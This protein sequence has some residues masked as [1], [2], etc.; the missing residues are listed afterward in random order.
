MEEKCCKKCNS[1]CGLIGRKK[2]YFFLIFYRI[3]RRKVIYI[4]IYIYIYKKEEKFE[5]E[6]KM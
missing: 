2:K 6:K 5:V 3:K 1:R 4:Y